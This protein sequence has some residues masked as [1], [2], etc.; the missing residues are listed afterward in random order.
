MGVLDWDL[1]EHDEGRN[2]RHADS[3]FES[4]TM[5]AQGKSAGE[6]TRSEIRVDRVAAQ[7]DGDSRSEWRETG[8]AKSNGGF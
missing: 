2:D 3:I 7:K 4:V 1:L 6:W 8:P 5:R